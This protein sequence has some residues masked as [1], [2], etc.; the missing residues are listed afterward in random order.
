MRRLM[1][2]PSTASFLA[3]CLAVGCT[4]NV[5]WLDRDIASEGPSSFTALSIDTGTG[6]LDDA[7]VVVRG[8]ERAGASATAHLAGLLGAGDDPDAI[9]A[10]TSIDWT[11]RPTGML[12]VD[13]LTTAQHANVHVETLDVLV[14]AATDV[15]LTGDDGALFVHGITGRVE[16][17]TES[18]AIEVLGAGIVDL[19][20][21][22]G[23]LQAE[24]RAGTFETDSGAIDLMLTQ[25]VVASA[26]SGAVRGSI[27]GGGSITTR[28]GAIEVRLT[29]PLDRDLFL[30][31]DSGAIVLQIPRGASMALDLGAASGTVTVRVEGLA[32]EGDDIRAV[33]G[34]GGFTVRAR[35]SS[36][37]I[38]VVDGTFAG[39]D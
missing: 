34:D 27:G 12:V 33:L 11:S 18:G 25:W 16:A 4:F 17:R 22:S 26:D 29:G 24:A 6:L 31:A 5:A 8:S 28:S 30:E 19:A 7:S 39:E 35:A 38:H 14:P 3:A 2:A 36:G 13:V 9:T 37:S 32:H 10:E 23:A 15:T 1:R 20:A 21:S